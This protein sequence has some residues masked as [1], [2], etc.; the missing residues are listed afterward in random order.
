MKEIRPG[1]DSDQ[2]NIEKAFQLVK[3][4]I[5]SHSEIEPTLWAGAI[6]SVLIDGYMACDFSYEDFCNEWEKIKH[7]YKKWWDE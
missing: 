7:H 3:N 1:Q 6:W 4:L 5:K 2:E